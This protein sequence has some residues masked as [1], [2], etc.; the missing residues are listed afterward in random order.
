MRRLAS[1]AA[2]LLAAAWGPT[3]AAEPPDALAA[4]LRAHPEW[5]GEVLARAG[6]H[7]LQILYT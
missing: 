7:R 1:L 2:F 3:S 5:F 4:V 6:E